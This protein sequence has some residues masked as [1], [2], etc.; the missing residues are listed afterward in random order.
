M[1]KENERKC[2]VFWKRWKVVSVKR[3]FGSLGEE[4]DVIRGKISITI[5]ETIKRRIHEDKVCSN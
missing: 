3:K 4:I 2:M 1:G 5:K